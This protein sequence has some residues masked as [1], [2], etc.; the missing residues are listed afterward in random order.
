MSGLLGRYARRVQ[1]PTTNGEC[2]S[3]S[4]DSGGWW[5][6]TDEVGR[7]QEGLNAHRRKKGGAGHERFPTVQVENSTAFAHL[8][9]VSRNRQDRYIPSLQECRWIHPGNDTIHHPRFV[10]TPYARLFSRVTVHGLA[11]GQR[12][13]TPARSRTTAPRWKTTD[14]SHS[15]ADSVPPDQP[16]P[17][18]PASPPP[19]A[20]IA[21]CRRCRSGNSRRH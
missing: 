14:P 12:T 5:L 17:V 11:A 9:M 18:L 15:A 21:R 6:T 8:L 7:R 20:Q 10:T 16:E 1:T 13:T 19:T 2:I 4:S 3:A